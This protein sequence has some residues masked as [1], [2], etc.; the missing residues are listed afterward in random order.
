MPQP[1]LCTPPPAVCRL[2]TGAAEAQQ[3][4]ADTDGERGCAERGA[5][6]RVVLLLYV[7]HD[8]AQSW[9][10]ADGANVAIFFLKR[11]YI[12][13]MHTVVYIAHNDFYLAQF[14]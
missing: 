7:C 3:H 14:L 2:L 8:S 1:P 4:L 9:W 11:Q 5:S 10:Q 12:P 6:V 13:F